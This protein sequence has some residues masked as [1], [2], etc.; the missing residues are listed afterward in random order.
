MAQKPVQMDYLKDILPQPQ[1]DFQE[2]LN[3]L[4]EVSEDDYDENIPF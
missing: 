2:L 3:E 1:K 4:D